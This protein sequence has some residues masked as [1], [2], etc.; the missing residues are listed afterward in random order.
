MKRLS[1]A[2]GLMVLLALTPLSFAQENG[3]E[4]GGLPGYGES[5]GEPNPSMEGEEGSGQSQEGVEP[6]QQETTPD[7]PSDSGEMQ[8]SPSD[9]D[10]AAQDN[11]NQDNSDSENADSGSQDSG[12]SAQPR[13]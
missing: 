1:F 7:N 2:A 11:A 12:D 4:S 9:D 10:N 13:E 8:G 3:G 5:S 6:E